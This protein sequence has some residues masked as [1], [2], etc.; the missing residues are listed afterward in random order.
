M[1]AQ[2]R[3]TVCTY[4]LVNLELEYETIQNLDIAPE[5]SGLFGSGR[6]LSYEHATLMKT[7][8]WDKYQVVT[9]AI[10]NENIN[11]LRKS[12][13]QLSC[14]CLLKK[15]D[16]VGSEDYIY[17][18]IEKVKITIEGNPNMIYSQ[19]VKNN[20][21]YS[22]AKRKCGIFVL[23][24]GPVNFT[25]HNLQ[26]IQYQLCCKLYNE[27]TIQ[28]DHSSSDWLCKKTIPAVYIREGVH[29]ALRYHHSFVPN[30]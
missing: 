14:Y 16:S 23:S 2:N 5:A 11:L 1:T 13:N 21:F 8:D 7:V 22:E 4:T 25:N 9:N 29:E 12:M 20:T 15:T 27:N 6:S 10:Y 24:D 30:V 28:Y 17:P 19:G 26:S 18:N 3:S